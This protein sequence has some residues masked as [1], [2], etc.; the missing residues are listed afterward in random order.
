VSADEV[1]ASWRNY[2]DQ[3][4]TA[5]G[6]D[7]NS[8]PPRIA[9]QYQRLSKDDRAVVDR[10]LAEQLQPKDPAPDE[11]W[12]EDENVRF[13]PEFLIDEFRITSALPA[14][15]A[16]A[17]WLESQDTPGAPYEWAK[18]NRIIGKLVESPSGA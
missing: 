5:A 11:P 10:L 15:R 17:N 2:C 8:V 16:L 9:E 4:E 3:V 12:Y 18:V 13:I 1:R 14:L 7:P 6:K